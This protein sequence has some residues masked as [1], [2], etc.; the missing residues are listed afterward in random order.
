MREQKRMRYVAAAVLI[1]CGLCAYCR[2]EQG[3]ARDWPQF[4]GL[5]RDGCSPETGLLEAW[6]ENGLEALWVAAGLGKGFSSAA[7]VDDRVYVTGMLGEENEGYL[8][9]F[10]LSGK[11]EWRQPYGPEYTGTYP[12]PR[13]T[14]TFAAG[15]AYLMSG[16]GRVVCCDAASGAVAWSR[17]VAGEFRGEIPKMGFN[18]SLLVDGGKVFCTPGGPDASLV[19]IDAANGNTLWT[20]KGFGEQSAYCSPILI[21][22]GGSRLLVTLT[23]KSVVAIAPESGILVWHFPFDAD[24]VDQNHSIM[25]VYQDGHLYVTSGHRKGGQMLELSPDGRQVTLGWSDET[26]GALH[27]GVVLVDGHLYGSNTKAKWVCLKLTDGAV[28]YEA[29]GAGMGSV[30]YADGMLY[31]YGEKGTLA[32]VKASPAAHETVSSFKITQ[33]TAQHWPHPVIAGGRLYIRH[34]DALIAFDISAR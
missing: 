24:E 8:F 14:P 7:I 29:D 18:E 11:L 32:L 9:R 3:A 19:A 4:R 27:G 33:G 13:G 23:A 20:T 6:P 34:G 21:E 5:H 12:G 17:D 30:A 16:T 1:A 2:A 25:P 28:C 15:R 26:L 10:D 22:R 31:C